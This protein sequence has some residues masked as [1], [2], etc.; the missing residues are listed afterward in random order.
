MSQISNDVVDDECIE[1]DLSRDERFELLAAER[2]RLALA[3]LSERDAP[4]GLDDLATAVAT[5][6]SDDGAPEN[7]VI[8]RTAVSLHHVHLPRLGDADVVDYDAGARRVD[9][10]KHV[11]AVQPF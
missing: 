8:D 11:S 4:L 10:A 2:R 6:Q 9:D 1:A 5:R 7:E 3:V